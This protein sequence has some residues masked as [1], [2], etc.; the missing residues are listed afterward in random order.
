[1]YKQNVDVT[2]F[3]VTIGFINTKIRLEKETGEKEYVMEWNKEK[4]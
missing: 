4:D 2:L 3:Y 1:M